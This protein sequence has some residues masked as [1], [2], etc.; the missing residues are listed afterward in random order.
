MSLPDC[1]A[2]I[3]SKIHYLL[4]WY[5]EVVLKEIRTLSAKYSITGCSSLPN[6]SVGARV[7]ACVA[8]QLVLVSTILLLELSKLIDR[9]KTK[10]T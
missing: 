10:H 4:L 8:S 5:T 2:Q 1:G 3:A 7:G 9:T 6:T